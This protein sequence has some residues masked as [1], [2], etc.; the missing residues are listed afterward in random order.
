MQLSFWIIARPKKVFN[1]AIQMLE[2]S[3]DQKW[4][5]TFV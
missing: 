1:L 4:L 3:V 5:L 2:K